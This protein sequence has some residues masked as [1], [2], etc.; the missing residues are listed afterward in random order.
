MEETENSKELAKIVQ[1]SLSEFHAAMEL[2]EELSVK[3]GKRTTQIIRFTMLGM[4]VLACAMFYLISTLTSNMND[5]VDGMKYM[6]I[7]MENMNKHFASVKEH[8][9]S[10]KF[11]VESMNQHISVMPV[12][13]ASVGT[14]SDGMLSMKVDMEK[15]S[16]NMALMEK[17]MNQMA[18]DMANMSYQFTGL[19]GYVGSMGYNV[20]RMAAPIKFF[21]LP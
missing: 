21:P 18:L 11:S 14:M 1:D 8:T 12:M 10:M 19:N 4:F 20:N 2:R 5:I 13:N 17:S 6:S 3:I 9:Q 15:M 16:T 7:Y